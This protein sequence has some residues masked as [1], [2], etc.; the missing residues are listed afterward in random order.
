MTSLKQSGCNSNR[1][2]KEDLIN[3]TLQVNSTTITFLWMTPYQNYTRNWDPMMAEGRITQADIDLLHDEMAKI[4]NYEMQQYDWKTC[5]LAIPGINIILVL[6]ACWCCVINN[7]VEEFQKER[8]IQA[9]AVLDKLRPHFQSKGCSLKMGP[10][11]GWLCIGLDF[12]MERLQQGGGAG[13]GAPP[14]NPFGA[15]MQAPMG[16][17]RF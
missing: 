13:Y 11:G 9:D 14:N 2:Y 4:P 6:L 10:N 12:K 17:P 15:F 8:K 7:A 3:N 1:R 5:L 16:A